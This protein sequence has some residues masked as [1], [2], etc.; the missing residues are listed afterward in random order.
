MMPQHRGFQIYGKA[1]PVIE[2]LLGKITQ[3][4]PTG[5]IDFSRPTGSLVELTRFRLPSMRFDDEE[6]AERVGIEL[7]RLLVEICWH[8]IT[9]ARRQTERQL[10]Q[11]SRSRH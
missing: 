8:D 6:L 7:G 10:V 11:R 5:S 9:I 3:W 1:E 4:F 2:T